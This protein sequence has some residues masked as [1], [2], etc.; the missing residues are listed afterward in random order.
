MRNKE[1]LRPILCLTIL[2]PC[3]NLV[4]LCKAA[5]EPA[6]TLNVDGYQRSCGVEISQRDS[7]IDVTWPLDTHR[8]GRMT[9]DLS[10]SEPLIHS[11]AV[12]RGTEPFRP[13]A[14]GLDPILQ[15]RVGKRDLDKRGG[16]TIFFDRMQRKPSEVFQAEVEATTAV[17][18][19]TAS[20]AT[21]TIGDL[22]A[23]PFHGQLRWTFYSGNPFVL[24]E[25]L[26]RTE[27]KATAYLYDTGLVCRDAGPTRVTWRDSLGPLRSEAA[28]SIAE[29]RH[30]AVRGRA[31]GADFDAGSIA[32]F[33]PPHR[34]FY[35]LDFS[36]NLSN[37]WVGP[38][39]GDRP[40]PFGFGIRHDPTGD[41]R[42]VPWVNAPAG[43]VQ[44]M[45]LFMLLSDGPAEQALEEVA[46]LTRDDRFAPLDGHTVFSSHYHV[47][48]TRELLNAQQE[49]KQTADE[50]GQLP[51][52]GQYRIPQR[53]QDPGFMRTFRDSGIDIVHLAEFHFGRTPRM[54][55]RERIEHLELLH[56][57]CRRLSDEKFLLLPGEEPNVHLGG[58]WISFF[59]KPVY[60]V[61]NRPEG[62]PFV[63][64]DPQL[65]RVYHVGSE[66]DVLRLLRAEKGLA[67]TAHARI[68][69]STGFPDGYRDRLFFQSDRFLGAAWKAMP[70]D[71]SQPRLGS[72]VLDLLDDMSNWGDP[73]YVLGEVDV[74]K[75]EPDHELYAHMSVN[76]LRLDEIPSFDEGWQP[77]LDALRE[78]RFFVTTGEVLIPEFTV[79]GCK[80]GE[81]AEISSD[82]MV[83]VRLQLQWT[84][85]LAYAEIIMGN[86]RETKRHK[87]DLSETGSFGNELLSIDVDASGQRWLR[88][89]AWDVA[90]NGAFTQPV[91]L[92]G[93]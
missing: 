8:R 65:G 2:C 30:L 32:L 49:S 60:W 53:L 86:G 91:W 45:G 4:G 67:W 35:P 11:T 54:D 80:S 62:T 50:T 33:P 9:F 42:Y 88:V 1:L 63:S 7:R 10:D 56:A 70:A 81:R 38:S 31:I 37:I 3:I 26:L 90:T 52:G 93:E 40:L 69:G 79:N 27:Q 77:V 44:E 59:P 43:T 84:F 68:K 75:I 82:G 89:E 22:S 23:G 20:R 85:P 12:S 74:F 72:R 29:A 46:R 78:G 51:T 58:H 5:E 87:V 61:L 28:Q 17:A 66:A 16:W 15:L 21:L 6:I 36:D 39:Y 25:A 73:K 24:Q 19:S 55:Q 71:L 47:E 64:D 76:Y 14:K 18:E 48:H 83:K 57:E 41:N 34:Y 92:V 13:I